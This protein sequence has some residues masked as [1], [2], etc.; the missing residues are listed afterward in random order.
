MEPV[1]KTQ[2]WNWVNS[3][4]Y[5]Q[6]H[7]KP[8]LHP[9]Q[10]SVFCLYSHKCGFH[11]SGIGID[12]EELL[13]WY[14][15]A[16]NRHKIPESETVHERWSRALSWQTGWINIHDF[17]AELLTFRYYEWAV[18]QVAINERESKFLCSLWIWWWAQP[19]VCLWYIKKSIL[20]WTL[21]QDTKK[22]PLLTLHTITQW[23]WVTM[24]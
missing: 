23:K 3:G 8:H 4:S 9:V 10:K 6:L 18:N 7:S 24:K 22:E 16:V 11:S 17:A 19:P 13:L 5:G 15:G 21:S 12:H 1:A 20:I 2:Q 14:P